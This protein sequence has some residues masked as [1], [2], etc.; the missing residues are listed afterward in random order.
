MLF[1]NTVCAVIDFRWQRVHCFYEKTLLVKPIHNKVIFFLNRGK[2]DN[3]L[4]FQILQPLYKTQHDTQKKRR[5]KEKKISLWG[6]SKS[7]MELFPD[8]GGR[9]GVMALVIRA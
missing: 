7:A 2:F 3:Q 8:A 5:K 4:L 9:R 6:Q 1:I